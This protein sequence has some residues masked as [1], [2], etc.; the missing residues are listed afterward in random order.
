MAPLRSPRRRPAG[1]VRRPRG[2]VRPR[3]AAR[4][5]PLRLLQRVRAPPP[6]SAGPRRLTASPSPAAAP[7]PPRPPAAASDPAPPRLHAAPTPCPVSL[8]SISGRRPRHPP[9]LELQRA[10]TLAVS[11]LRRPEP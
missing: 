8:L 11:D 6:S 1:P 9:P 4:A 3:P 2:P 10:A 5:A 7:P